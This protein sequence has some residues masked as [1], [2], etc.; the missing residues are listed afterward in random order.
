MVRAPTLT[1]DIPRR[2]QPADLERERDETVTKGR[3]PE[4]GAGEEDPLWAD[5][6]GGLRKAPLV[7]LTLG[8]EL[9]VDH[10]A[11]AQ[12]HRAIHIP[13]STQPPR[14]EG[15]VLGNGIGGGVDAEEGG[16][17]GSGNGL[18][19]PTRGDDLG[20]EA[21]MEHHVEGAVGVEGDTASHQHSVHDLD[22]MGG[23]VE[24]NLELVV[25]R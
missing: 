21:G 18:D 24:P 10:P 19:P 13:G 9:V 12:L 16:L 7:L 4:T 2:V 6:A 8:L 3:Y 17:D 11:V 1:D 14:F 5:D 25:G 20:S 23:R 22:P 15:D